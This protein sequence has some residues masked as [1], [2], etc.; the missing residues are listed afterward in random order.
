MYCSLW[1]NNIHKTSTSVSNFKLIEWNISTY[2]ALIY[3]VSFISSFTLIYHS[4]HDKGIGLYVV[5]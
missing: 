3:D 1:I 4:F 5:V 2:Q